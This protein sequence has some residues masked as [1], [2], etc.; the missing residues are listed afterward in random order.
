MGFGTALAGEITAQKERLF[1][2]IPVAFGAGI[3]VYSALSV[4]PNRYLGIAATAVL[5]PFLARAW[6]HHH[7]SLRQFIVFLV[8][9]GLFCGACGF[10]TAQIGTA[11]HG[12]KILEKSVGPKTAAGFVES[13]E[14]LGGKNGSRVV[15]SDVSI[16]GVA[17]PPKKLRL[18]FKKDEGL[19]AGQMVSTLVKVDPPSQAV[20]PGA[21]DFRRHLFFEGIGGVGFSFTAAKI[22][23]TPESG[24]FGLFFERTR[25]AIDGEITRGAGPVTAG[26]MTALITGER[27][28]IAEEDDDAMRNSGLYH[29]LSISGTHVAMVAGVLFFFT[30]LFLAAFP[31]IA[32]RC[33]IKKIAAIVALLGS[34]FY[35]LLAGADVPA[36]RSLMTTGLVMLAIMLDRSP[37]SMRLVAVSA[38]FVLMLA[39]HSLI[40][41]SFQMSFAAVAALICFF[42]YIRAWWMAWYSKAGFI[43]KSVLYLIGIMLTSLIA[44]T[45]T[46]FFS[47]YHFQQ[48]AVFGVLSNMLAVPLTG[49]VIMPAAILALLLMPFGV[50]GFAIKVMEWGVVWMLAIAHWTAGLDDAVIHVSQWPEATFALFSA[51]LVLFLLWGG[52]IGKAVAVFTMLAGLCLIPFTT[53]PD[54]YISDSG[55]LVAVRGEDGDLY[56]SSGRKDK[57]AAENWLRLNAREGEKPKTFRDK[58]APVL[59]DEAGCRMEIAEHHV[60]IVHTRGAYFEDRDWADVMVAD[61]PLPE[62]TAESDKIVIDL[63]DALDHGA[64]TVYVRG[65]G[66]RV[67][68]VGEEAG[69]RPWS[70]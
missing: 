67:E 20:A 53:R 12:T 4:E 8:W 17:Q 9:A 61:I 51:G 43:R 44:G 29:L 52:W 32:L 40:G 54:I 25:Q 41:V 50:A 63:F 6:R 31:W 35:V 60:S 57:F 47:L 69:E 46:G 13:V 62:E 56:F 34:A 15:L 27:G 64:H 2:W 55:K 49:F 70:K 42:D 33:P 38:L 22:L 65:E 48:F 39:P 1:L 5:I 3:A 16:E 36:V 59:C 68:S 10:F 14:N 28:A 21:Y 24:G 66:I 58:A 19:E 30:R 26:I 7:D 23:E 37:L 18:K 45:V 11:V